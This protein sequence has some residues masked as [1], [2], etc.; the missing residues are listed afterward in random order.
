VGAQQWTRRYNGLSRPVTFAASTGDS[1]IAPRKNRLTG[2][3]T[4]PDY[5]AVIQAV[6]RRD[7]ARFVIDG[8]TAANDLG[9]TNAV[10]A[11]IEVPVDNR[12]KPI[13]LGN[14]EI[15]FKPAAPTAFIGRVGRQCV[16]CKRC[17]GC[18]TCWEIPRRAPA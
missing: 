13:K 16:S 4:V 9:L 5:R 2:R 3:D 7:Q 18:R 12:L 14:Q 10:P 8:M 11:Q 15:H 17:I 1:T 6:T